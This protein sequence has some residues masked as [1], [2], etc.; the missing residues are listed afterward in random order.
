MLSLTY[1]VSVRSFLR[2]TKERQH[3]SWVKVTA[4]RLR[5]F[6]CGDVDDVDE[7]WEVAGWVEVSWVEVLHFQHAPVAVEALLHHPQGSGQRPDRWPREAPVKCWDPSLAGEKQGVMQP[8][9]TR[10]GDT[11]R[12]MARWDKMIID[13]KAEHLRKGKI[14]NIS[15]EQ[16]CSATSVLEGPI[17]GWSHRILT[18]RWTVTSTAVEG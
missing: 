10:E 17:V 3:L 5:S 13:E 16:R 8:T 12:W 2:A 18:M 6:G 1:I 14:Y 9:A 7:L 4:E 11:A 15:V